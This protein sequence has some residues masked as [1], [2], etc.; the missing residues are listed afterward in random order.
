MEQFVQAKQVESLLGFI[1]KVTFCLD[2]FVN[3]RSPENKVFRAEIRM[4]KGMKL[5]SRGM[6]GVQVA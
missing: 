1:W 6:A 5:F 2:L 4:F 3:A